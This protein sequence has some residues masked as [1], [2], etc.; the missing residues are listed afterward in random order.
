M[1]LTK[2]AQERIERLERMYPGK[3]RVEMVTSDKARIRIPEDTWEFEV[4]DGTL[5]LN[6]HRVHALP[7]FEALAY[8]RAAEAIAAVRMGLSEATTKS[9]DITPKKITSKNIKHH[10]LDLFEV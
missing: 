10:Q 5:I 9:E 6:P 1:R 7:A 2:K 8:F 4:V 3:V